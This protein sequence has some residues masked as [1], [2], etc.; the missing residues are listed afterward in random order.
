MQGHITMSQLELDRL[1]ILQ[2]VA[3]RGFTQAAAAQS[4]GLSYRQVKRIMAS[5]R[6]QGA[7]GLTSRKRGQSDNRRLP[8]VYTEHVLDL[9]REHR[10]AMK[11]KRNQ[12]CLIKTALLPRSN[13][14]IS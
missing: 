5:S 12:P 6:R 1:Q 10:A 9:V 4:L 2:R 13:L 8:A 11:A 3:E 7:A 14:W